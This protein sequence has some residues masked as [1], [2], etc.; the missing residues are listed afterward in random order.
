MLK[1]VHR[2]THGRFDKELNKS[3]LHLMELIPLFQ[4]PCARSLLKIFQNT[5]TDRAYIHHLP[6]AHRLILK[7]LHLK[8]ISLRIKMEI[9]L[10]L[11]VHIFPGPCMK[12][13]F[14]QK[15]NQNFLVR[16]YCGMFMYSIYQLL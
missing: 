7:P 11:T 2:I 15:T 8:Q 5:L 16:F 13:H 10:Y 12:L 1:Y 6:L 3:N 4:T 9:V 14:Q